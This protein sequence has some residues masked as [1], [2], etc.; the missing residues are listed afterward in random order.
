MEVAEFEVNG[1]SITVY[2]KG[3]EHRYVFSVN[4]GEKYI[5]MSKAKGEAVIRFLKEI[6]REA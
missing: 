5:E 2:W 6:L 4:Y 3:K 1:N